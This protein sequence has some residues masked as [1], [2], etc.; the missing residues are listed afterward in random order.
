M[1]SNPGTAAGLAPGQPF[2]P[3]KR[4]HVHCVPEPLSRSAPRLAPARSSVTPLW[5]AM[6]ARTAFAFPRQ[7]L[8][9]AELAVSERQVRRYLRELEKAQLLHTTRR[10]LND[11]NRYAFLWHPIFGDA[12]P[13]IHRSGHPRPI[14]TGHIRP[15]K[16]GH[17]RP[18]PLRKKRVR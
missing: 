6:P 14:K 12:K 1:S 2:I 8:L 10:G 17:L 4:F 11:S 15:F 16:S 3:Y 18:I 7:Q 13:L 9:A 5:P